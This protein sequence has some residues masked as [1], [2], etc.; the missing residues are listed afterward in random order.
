MHPV[1][2][3]GGTGINVV[4]GHTT[5]HILDESGS[6][7]NHQR[8]ADD[9]KDVGLL[10]QAGSG[11]HIG[12]GLAKEHDVR[13]HR[14]AIGVTS[15]DTGN[16]SL[17]GQFV[18]RQG[19]DAIL[20]TQRAHL[21]QLTVQVQHI[22]AAGTLMQVIH[23]LCDDAHVKVFLQFNKPQMGGI[24]LGTNQLLT[25]LVIKLVDERGIAQEA[26][27]AGHVHYRIIL[28]QAIGIAK[29]LDTALGADA[30][31]RRDH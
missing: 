10:S 14:V 7:I 13:S 12:D 11:L 17:I 25:A 9:D 1:G 27:M 4:N 29:G 16:Q 15:I 30:S 3:C 18:T 31:T 2:H 5:L 8:R 23:V 21:H 28:P 6:R 22:A 19:V 24:G 26:L 20:S